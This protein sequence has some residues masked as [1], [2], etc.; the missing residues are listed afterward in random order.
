[1]AAL[2]AGA[3]A[4]RGTAHYVVLGLG[5]LATLI[6]T[7]VVTRIAQRALK[8]SAALEQPAEGAT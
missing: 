3:A 6:V 5:L 1:V 8:S 4:E 2:A 7:T